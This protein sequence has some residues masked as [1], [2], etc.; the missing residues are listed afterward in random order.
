MQISPK[1]PP[2]RAE[3]KNNNNNNNARRIKNKIKRQDFWVFFRADESVTPTI[4][5]FVTMY[6]PPPTTRVFI[7]RRAVKRK[8]FWR[9]NRRQGGEGISGEEPYLCTAV[10][11]FVVA[12][13]SRAREKGGRAINT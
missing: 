5:T 11:T 13:A 10:Y 9:Q 6:T 7:D 12:N 3:R 2:Y 8:R 1:L 4:C